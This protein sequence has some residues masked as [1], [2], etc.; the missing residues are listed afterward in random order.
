LRNSDPAE[1]WIG[2]GK[3][4]PASR[5]IIAVVDREDTRPVYIAVWGGAMD[6]AQAIWT[7]RNER[8]PGAFQ[9]FIR[10]MRVHQISW[11]DKGTVWI[12]ENVP[13]LFLILSLEAND[14][15]FSEGPAAAHDE[16]WVS[17]N[18]RTGHGPLGGAYPRARV[19]GVKEG[20]TPS[21]LYLLPPGL[22]DPDH[23]EWGSWG[24]RFKRLNA[25]SRF[26]VD[27]EDDHPE[28][29]EARRRSSWTVGRWNQAISNDFAARMDWCVRSREEANHHPVVVL[30]G[31]HTTAVLR[32]RV[33][34][35][36]RIHLDATGT[37][38]PDSGDRVRYSWMHY[39]EPGSYP[40]NLVIRDVSAMRTSFVAPDVTEPQTIHLILM[41][42]DDGDP[43][44]TS[45]RR[46]VFEV[47]P[48]V[49]DGASRGP[50][51]TN[52]RSSV[53]TSE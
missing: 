20:D 29:Q 21:F 48:A 46:I 12:W 34:A 8:S 49:K 31:D 22:S 9:K 4:T 41:A 6:L 30:N 2:A 43:Q 52:S 38:D 53:Y 14:G 3:A 7:V 50:G 5:H 37:E 42:T 24:G 35:G 26:Y 16:P 51:N 17:A 28:T 33:I 19:A 23:P 45:Y 25:T 18:V 27:A 10:K 13:E 44:L 47:A 1:E 15:I 40:G 36:E 11:Q 32:R 39:R